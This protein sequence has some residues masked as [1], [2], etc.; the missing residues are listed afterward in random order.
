MQ[1]GKSA[2][3]DPSLMLPDVV[4]E[5]TELIQK[6]GGSGL[7]AV[8]ENLIDEIWTDRPEAPTSKIFVH[9]EKYSGK[10][11]NMKLAELRAVI[12][13]NEASGFYATMLDDIAW[14]FNLRGSDISYNPVFYAYALA[15]ASTAVL[16]VDESKI[17][18]AVRKHLVANEVQIRPYESFYKDV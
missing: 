15:T 1:D 3:V 9:P 8:P 13:K 18:E 17:D 12:S 10:D 16:Y 11:V 5:L 6:A 14:L 2:A 4:T 7:V